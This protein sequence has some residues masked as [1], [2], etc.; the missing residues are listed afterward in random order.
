[1]KPAERHEDDD[2]LDLSPAIHWA[3][4]A[5]RLRKI[6][7]S[8]IVANQLTHEFLARETG[9]DERQIARCLKDD[10]GA[11][12]PLALVVCVAWH[13]KAGVFLSGFAGMLHY[14]ITPRKPDLAAENKRLRGE[15]SSVR[16]QIDRILGS[17][18]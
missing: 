8:A 10:G 16:E 6:L 14:D 2:Q 12:P 1:M 7:N 15:L 3:K 18:S 11:H 17:A 13:D 4:K 5:A 9:I